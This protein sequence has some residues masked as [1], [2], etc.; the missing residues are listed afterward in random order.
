ME[1]LVRL[2]MTSQRLQVF[3]GI[4][5]ELRHLLPFKEPVTSSLEGQYL[6]TEFHNYS[7]AGEALAQKL[8]FDCVYYLC[9]L[10]SQRMAQMLH[11]KY[12]GVGER[13]VEEVASLVGFKLPKQY[14]EPSNDSNEK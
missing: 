1:C 4:L 13:P 11:E 2:V 9:L 6:I 5:R 10:R 8:Y 7:Q 14:R 3:R 12:K